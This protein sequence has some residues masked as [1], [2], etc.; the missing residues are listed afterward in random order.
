MSHVFIPNYLTVSGAD[1]FDRHMM[2]YAHMC[3]LTVILTKLYNRQY[4]NWN[5]RHDLT[6][7]YRDKTLDKE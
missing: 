2:S 4:F 5:Q 1:T 6:L 7:R 3:S